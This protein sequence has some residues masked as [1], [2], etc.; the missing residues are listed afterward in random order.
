MLAPIV[1]H[2]GPVG[3]EPIGGKDRVSFFCRHIDPFDL[4]IGEIA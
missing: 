3:T 1:D 2:R 4:I